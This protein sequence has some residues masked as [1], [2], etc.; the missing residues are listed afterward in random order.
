MTTHTI[1]PGDYVR[2]FAPARQ[3]PVPCKVLSIAGEYITCEPLA[4]CHV[5]TY[6]VPLHYVHS[7]INHKHINHN[8]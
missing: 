6:T 5:H 4:K 7:T 3:R 8:D 2:I 1:K